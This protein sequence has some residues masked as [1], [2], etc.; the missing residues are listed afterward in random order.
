ML[1]LVFGVAL[2]AIA[3]LTILPFFVELSFAK[4]GILNDF[5]Q[6]VI[7]IVADLPFL[8]LGGSWG[9]IVFTL[10][11][12]FLPGLLLI[13]A[14]VLLF[15]KKAKSQA[16]Y[17]FGDVLIVLAALLFAVLFVMF[18]K[19]LFGEER[20]IAWVIGACAGA[21]LLLFLVAVSLTS[22][23]RKKNA[24]KAV[25]SESEEPNGEIENAQAEQPAATDSTQTAATDSEQSSTEQPPRERETQ[26]AEQPSA[27]EQKKTSNR[28]EMPREESPETM[29]VPRDAGSVSDVVARAYGAKEE[30]PRKN[31]WD[32]I[33]KL[34]SLLEEDVITKEEY[35]ALVNAYLKEQE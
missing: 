24:Q 6:G 32:K 19:K 34:R 22:K 30:K 7:A 3:V 8:Q 9:E 10:V 16:R 23:K 12:Y 17:V 20:A 28:I 5:H 11:A 4:E 25:A 18:A 26:K 29:Y 21:V 31:N 14:A 27:F 15:G 33:E 1:S 2:I 13:F 35:S